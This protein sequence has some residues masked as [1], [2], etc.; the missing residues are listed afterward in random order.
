MKRTLTALALA[1]ALPFGAHAAD[2]SYSYIEGGWQKFDIDGGTNA[3][4]WVANGSAALGENFHIYGGY[5]QSELDRTNIDADTWRLGVGWNTGINASNDLVVRANYV[6]AKTDIPGFQSVKADGY[7][8]EVGVRTAFGDRF[9]TYAAAGYVDV[10]RGSGDFYGKLGGQYK[11]TPAF[12]IVAQATLADGG[13][14]YFVGPRL[15]F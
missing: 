15:S 12:G 7:E 13:N 9:E 10:E 1:L 11:F 2:L 8:A 6:E 4:G 3:D 14:E 5:G